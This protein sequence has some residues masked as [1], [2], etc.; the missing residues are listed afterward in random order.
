M[1]GTMKKLSVFLITIALLFL[2][3]CA[4]NS[5]DYDIVATTLPVYDF[6]ATICDG[7]GLR[8]GRLVTENVSCL[9]DY[10]LQ[11]SQ[12]RMIESAD[13]VVISG[14]GLEAFLDD[15]LS[16]STAVIDASA[17][18]HVHSGEEHHEEHHDHG[19]DHNHE[20]DP[21]I[22]L[23]TENAMI[24]AQN[25]CSQLIV[26]Y[27]QYQDIF[28]SNLVIL[29]QSLNELQHYG[30][31]QLQDLQ[32]RE[33]ITFHDGFAYFA[34][35][36]DLSILEA[37]EEE[38]GSE[39]SA[40]EIIHLID[41]VHTHQLPAIFTEVSGSDACA[42]IIA[43]ETDVQIFTLDMAMSG[44]SYFKTMY[45]NIDTVKEALG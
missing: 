11:V 35:G 18:T 39:A 17:N 3:S 26:A 41:L 42:G 45:H 8:V 21:H 16:A 29:Q 36:F 7:S 14:A 15:A 9:H 44:N 19:H 37:V 20:Q 38:S 24:M 34:E 33:L 10:T 25:I 2:C 13:T 5:S 43:A 6:T 23:S 1:D 31:T 28:R 4:G 40:A 27:P 32:T 12:M 30:E 22:W